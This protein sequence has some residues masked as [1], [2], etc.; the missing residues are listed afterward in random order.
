MR[1]ADFVKKSRDAKI[2]RP[3]RFHFQ[4][5]TPLTLGIGMNL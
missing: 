2:A 3:D 5:T 4:A 1:R